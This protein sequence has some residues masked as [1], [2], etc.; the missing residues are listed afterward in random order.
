M[1]RWYNGS[2]RHTNN[3]PISAA[4]HKAIWNSKTHIIQD[5]T[6][7]DS[8]HMNSSI[9]CFYKDS[10]GSNEFD[11]CRPLYIITERQAA[12]LKS[13]HLSGHDKPKWSKTHQS[14]TSS[15]SQNI[16]TLDWQLFSQSQR[17]FHSHILS[18]LG[19]WLLADFLLSSISH[20]RLPKSIGIYHTSNTDI[21]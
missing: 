6:T 15:V 8:F 12:K 21:W 10:I 17:L 14:G 19:Q 5:Q 18:W 7:S 13:I 1:E 11:K 3:R 2:E 20:Q 9:F 16:K 4:I